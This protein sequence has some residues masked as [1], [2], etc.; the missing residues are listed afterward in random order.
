M[1]PGH[2]A[3][4][5]VHLLPGQRLVRP[6]APFE[7]SGLS[8]GLTTSSSLPDSGCQASRGDGGQAGMQR[9]ARGTS[10]L[11]EQPDSRRRWQRQLPGLSFVVTRAG[12]RDQDQ[13]KV[14][15]WLVRPVPLHPPIF[16]F[17][18]T[19]WSLLHPPHS[20]YPNLTSRDD[21]T[22]SFT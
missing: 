9:L 22:N 21:E 17:V 10:L 1:N 8:E 3:P 18:T 19:P 5:P 7:D 16:P 6:E 15:L 13:R 20:P 14:G 11:R 4:C 12:G 2:L